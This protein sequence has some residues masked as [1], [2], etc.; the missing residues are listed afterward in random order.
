MD[1]ALDAGNERPAPSGWG[2]IESQIKDSSALNAGRIRLLEGARKCFA[3][4]GYGGTTVNDIAEA[5]GVSIGSFY[6]YVRSKEDLLWL[7]AEEA[8]SKIQ[9]PIQEIAESDN[10][11]HALCFAIETLIRLTDDNADLMALLHL[12]Y[13]YMP[14]Q[15]KIRVR[16]QDAELVGRFEGL[17]RGGVKNGSFRCED[18]FLVAYTI[19]M[20]ATTWV[21][22]RRSMKLSLDEFIDRQCEIVKH[23]V[24]VRE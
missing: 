8:N 18:P 9:R 6:K 23:L 5:A 12:E 16:E 4:R 11:L 10:D 7:L 2:L 14:P 3:D 21:L 22:K 17:I 20:M 1:N 15:C 24:G 19:E 13:R